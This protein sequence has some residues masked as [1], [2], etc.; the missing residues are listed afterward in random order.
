MMS[1]SAS[2][3]PRVDIEQVFILV[4]WLGWWWMGTSWWLADDSVIAVASQ[5]TLVHNSSNSSDELYLGYLWGPCRAV[6]YK[7]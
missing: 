2:I 6:E 7:G 5:F 1:R 3:K 4:W